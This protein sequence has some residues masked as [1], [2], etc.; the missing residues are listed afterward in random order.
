[1]AIVLNKWIRKMKKRFVVCIKK[2]LLKM[3]V[4][5]PNNDKTKCDDFYRYKREILVFQ[6]TGCTFVITNLQKVAKQLKVPSDHLSKYLAK[7]CGQPILDGNK[8]KSIPSNVES[9]VEKYIQ[10]YV[11]CMRCNLPELLDSGWICKS[12]GFDNTKK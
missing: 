12:C 7:N 2:L 5:I 6:K 9:T 11:L 1:M 4:P 8:I 3:S 10:K